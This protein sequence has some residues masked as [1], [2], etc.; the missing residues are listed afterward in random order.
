MTQNFEFLNLIICD[1]VREEV[2]RKQIIIGAYAGVILLPQIPYV[3]A[4]FAVRFEVMAKRVHYEQISCRVVKP[5]GEDLFDSIKRPLDVTYQEFPISLFFTNLWSTF[6]QV[7]KY[8]IFLSMD[9]ETA[10]VGSFRIVT[11]AELP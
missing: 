3:V 11:A 10:E 4:T 8:N 2:S 7:G 9:E 6:D 1:D 5:N